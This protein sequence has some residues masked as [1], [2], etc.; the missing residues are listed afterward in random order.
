ML[1]NLAK[2]KRAALAESGKSITP[3]EN[4]RIMKEAKQEYK[5]E[6]LRIKTIRIQKKIAKEQA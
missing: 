1:E 2:K 6:R 3:E 4:Q 5:E